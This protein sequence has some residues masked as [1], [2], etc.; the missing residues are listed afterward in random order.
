MGRIKSKWL[1]VCRR[2]LRVG[3]GEERR[4]C[5]CIWHWARGVSAA[6]RCITPFVHLSMTW[7]ALAWW[8]QREMRFDQG[9][10]P[11]MGLIIP[12]IKA[13]QQGA[14]DGVKFIVRLSSCDTVTLEGSSERTL[15]PGWFTGPVMHFPC[16]ARRKEALGGELRASGCEQRAGMHKINPHCFLRVRARQALCREWGESVFF[17]FFIYFFSLRAPGRFRAD[18]LKNIVWLSPAFTATGDWTRNLDMC[19]D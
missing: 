14:K 3:G 7:G 10:F 18:V 8:I 4:V 9:N 15:E 11:Q 1:R 2:G 16:R 6:C 12:W 19:P 13:C 5:Q 17:Y